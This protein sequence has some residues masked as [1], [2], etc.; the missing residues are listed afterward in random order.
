[1]LVKNQRRRPRPRG[2]GARQKTKLDQESGPTISDSFAG[3]V[4]MAQQCHPLVETLLSYVDKND[5]LRGGNLMPFITVP[6]YPVVV[7]AGR[8]V[9]F[10]AFLILSSALAIGGQVR[11]VD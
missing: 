4:G 10:L 6:K 8:L 1:M 7:C 11:Y 9:T 5:F 2:L 3:P